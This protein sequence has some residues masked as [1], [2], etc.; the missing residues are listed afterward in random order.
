MSRL[1][2][3]LQAYMANRAQGVSEQDAE[4]L[5]AR[6]VSRSSSL[7][8]HGR[9]ATLALALSLVLIVG[10][11]FLT[12]LRSPRPNGN[13]TSSGP[14]PA[15]P[16]EVVN[17]DDAST[18]F[19]LVTPFRLRD[20]KLLPGRPRLILPTGAGLVID[21]DSSCSNTT[22]R[23]V[24]AAAPSHNLRPA[25]TLTECYISPVL[26]PGTTLV[27]LSHGQNSGQAMHDLGTVS[28]DWAAGRITRTY[29]GLST[30]NTG[31]I[32]SDGTLLYTI[33]L[34]TGVLHIT[35][36]TTGARVADMASGLQSVGLNAGGM[37][38]TP[39]GRTLYLNEGIRIRAF[40]AHTGQAGAVIEFGSHPTST[41]SLPAWLDAWLGGV[42]AEAKEGL[43]AGHGIAIDPKGRLLA[44]ISIDDRSIAGIWIFDISGPI[45][46]VRHIPA[47]SASRTAGF[48]GVAFSRDGTVLYALSIEAQRGAIDVIDP[49][50]G[51]MRALANARFSD[52]LGIAGVEAA[53]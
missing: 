6:A 20:Q 53:N 7:P 27:L 42:T 11:V 40:D 37:A 26:V 17:L 35:N 1:E 43:E 39:D 44:A 14:L 15:V 51:R 31:L 23:V 50:S 21:P 5:V 49:E 22:I 41:S 45:R 25:V 48:R 3:E 18:S 2:G 24:D 10:A 46:E 16:N 8:R 29:P 38:L 32:S 9:N 36:L 4:L 13:L 47:P 52:L 33:D 34:E 12:Q 19:D 30:V 28:Y